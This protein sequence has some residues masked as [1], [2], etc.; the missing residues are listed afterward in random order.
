MRELKLSINFFKIITKGTNL[1]RS[2][3]L[4]LFARV[5]VAAATSVQTI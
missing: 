2:C 5:L 4:G 1:K 3:A